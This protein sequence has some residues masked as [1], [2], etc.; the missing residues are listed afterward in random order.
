MRHV[1]PWLAVAAFVL[2]GCKQPQTQA[3]V[4]AEGAYGAALLRCV[5]KATTLAESK[6]CRAKVNAEW[7]VTEVPK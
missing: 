2:D 3:Q 7:G 4:A 5:D 6:T 1:I